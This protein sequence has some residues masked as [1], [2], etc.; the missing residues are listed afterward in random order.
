[1]LEGRNLA[2]GHG[3]AILKGV[4]VTLEM[5][6][7]LGLCGPSGVGKTSLGRVLAGLQKPLAGEVLLD[8]A[9]LPKKGALPVQYL[10][11]APILAM[12]P[13]WRLARVLAEAG[14]YDPNLA[15]ALRV[16]E[17]WLVRYP[18]EVS[19]GQLMRIAILRAL[20][21]APRYLI[22][23]EIT[24]PLDPVTQAQVWQLL[25]QLCQKRGIGILA[26]SHDLPLLQRIADGGCLTLRR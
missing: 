15:A 1:M 20:L 25:L 12:N 3:Q 21:A 5:G 16:D 6:Q 19:G 10:H 2:I 26:I 18:H 23:D 9:P 24:A 8:G 7:I 14:S 22:A 4:N 17:A 13:R 11:Q